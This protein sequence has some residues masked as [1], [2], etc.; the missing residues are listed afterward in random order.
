[1]RAIDL[2]AIFRAPSASENSTA[3]DRLPVIV[4]EG[5]GEGP[6]PG[7][8]GCSA[9]G[10]SCGEPQGA[11]I[12][13]YPATPTYAG[14]A[15]GLAVGLLAFG[16]VLAGLLLTSLVRGTL[17]RRELLTQG[18]LGG[19]LL[20][21][22]VRGLLSL[23]AFDAR[24]ARQCSGP[25][26]REPMRQRID[27]LA[28]S[29]AAVSQAVDTERRRIERDLHDGVQQRLVALAMLLGYARRGRTPEQ[30]K[31]AG[32][33]PQGVPGRPDRAAGSGLADVSDGAGQSGAGEALT[34]VSERCGI[35]VRMDLA[36]TGR[37][38][39][40]ATPSPLFAVLRAGLSPEAAVTVAPAADTVSIAV[41]ELVDDAVITLTPGA[42]DDAVIALTPGAMEARLPDGLSGGRCSV[43]SP[44]RS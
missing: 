11:R 2:I 12:L 6:G 14:L 33:G 35:P 41:T 30:A 18:P 40:S 20:F 32:A 31:P 43:A 9:A 10:P 22:N 1:M 21:L 29:R 39:S 7:S 15:P 38:P 28:T 23:E 19:V 44:W 5:T 24:L 8:P 37:L 42:V 13:R 25:S 34:G 27:E 16:V 3:P 36:L 4:R 26:E 17:G